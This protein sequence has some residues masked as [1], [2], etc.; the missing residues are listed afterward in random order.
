[1]KVIQYQQK[2][3]PE[4]RFGHMSVTAKRGVNQNEEK[5][6]IIAMKMLTLDVGLQK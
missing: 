2:N 3:D 5:R 1:M 6:R 4:Y